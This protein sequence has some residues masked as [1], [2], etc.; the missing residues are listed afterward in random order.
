M[1]EEEVDAVAEELAKIGGI[2]W[3]PG[4]TPGPLLRVV[5]ERYRDRARVAIA[6]LDRLRAEKGRSEGAQDPVP[7]QTTPGHG[8]ANDEAGDRLQVGATVVYRPPGEKRAIPCRVERIEDGRAFL[9]P[10]P[11][12]E[13]GWVS[14]ESLV[15]LQAET[16]NGH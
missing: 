12:P 9:V 4:R 11:R 6:A 3:Y 14:I 15:P 16:E 10:C 13:I 5:S 1:T 7:E 8:H 2:A